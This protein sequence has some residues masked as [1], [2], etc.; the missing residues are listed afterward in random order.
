[1]FFNDSGFGNFESSIIYK[2]LKSVDIN[3]SNCLNTVPF[4]TCDCYIIHTDTNPMCCDMNNS[5]K[6]LL[7]AKDNYW[8]QWIYQFSHEYCHHLI[9]GRLNGNITGLKW[10]EEMICELSSMYNLY[11]V[12]KSYFHSNEPIE[13]R[14]AHSVQ[15]Y[16][17]DLLKNCHT[18][19]R[20]YIQ[21]SSI[22]LNQPVYHRDCYNVI[23]GAMLHLFVEYPSLWNVILYLGDTCQWNSLHEFFDY[24]YSKM[25]Y[26]FSKPLKKLNEL[27][28][29]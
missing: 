18:Y 17:H 11:L 29:S 9:N 19:Y 22:F 5:H 3:F 7:S 28:L 16:L 4:S 21:D 8:C 1:M 20:G 27:L 25:S 15:D 26:N 23:A 12:Y 10:F 24:L 13:N 2:L 6:I 14:Y